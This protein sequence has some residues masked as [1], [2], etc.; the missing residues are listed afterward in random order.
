MDYFVISSKQSTSW[1]AVALDYFSRA[2]ITDTTEKT[3]V[4][5]LVKA[6]RANSNI[7]ASL[8]GG[9][10][11]LVSPTSYGASLHNLM[12]SSYLLTEGVAPTYS[13]NGWSFNGSNQYL[14][15]GLIPSTALTLNTG[16]VQFSNRNIA[17]SNGYTYGAVNTGATNAWAFLPR[18]TTNLAV[19]L[20]YDSTQFTASTAA[21]ATGNFLFNI[22]NS[23]DRYIMKNG[24]SIATTAVATGGA[25]PAFECY[26]GCRNINGTP[27]NFSTNEITTLTQGLI[28]LSTTD[29]T[30]YCSLIDTYNLNV[31]AGGR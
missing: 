10:V 11:Y 18:T 2:G 20:S 30:H 26:I 8:S 19:M 9:F 1:D 6:L 31:I 24:V 25:R 21:G 15:T 12:S 3:A 4:N 5:T 17:Q 29:A 27:T 13:T 28:G 7:W 23:T 14:K 22:N 16:F